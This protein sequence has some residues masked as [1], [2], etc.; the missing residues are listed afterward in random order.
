METLISYGSHFGEYFTLLVT[1]M[2]YH[3]CTVICGH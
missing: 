1:A 2:M 3:V